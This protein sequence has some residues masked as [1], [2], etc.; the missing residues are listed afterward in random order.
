MAYRFAVERENHEDLASGSVLRSAPGLPAFPVRLATE[1]FQRALALRGL[2][3]VVLADP[4]CGSGYLLTALGLLHPE[5]IAAVLAAD[6]EADAVAVAR[7]NLALLSRDGLLA[8]RAEL[9]ELAGRFGKESH[10]L[11][12]AAADRLLTSLPADIPSTVEI[13][14]AFTGLSGDAD[15][16]LTD[17]PY[18]EQVH[19]RG[20]S[21]VD[22]LL[23]AVFASA[24]R[25]VVAVVARGRKVP[26]RRR[27]RESLKVGTRAVALFTAE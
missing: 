9:V 2:D 3:R 16:V 5:R 10:R 15:I 8:R 1:V 13:R 17:L 4:L 6:V 18:G 11:A 7:Q 19:W 27:A 23:D 26:A 24:P 21:D 12:V 14:D 22:A 25:A 20:Q